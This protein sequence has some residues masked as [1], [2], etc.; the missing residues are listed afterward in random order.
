[1]VV[2]T[3][4][5]SEPSVDIHHRSYLWVVV[6]TSLEMLLPRSTR[7][8]LCIDAQWIHMRQ[9]FIC[10]LHPLHFISFVLLNCGMYFIAGSVSLAYYLCAIC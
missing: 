2:Q 10:N 1:M 3:P 9:F 8:L 4:E 6:G 7:E 5:L